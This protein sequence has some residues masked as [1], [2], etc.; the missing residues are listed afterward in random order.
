MYAKKSEIDECSE[1]VLVNIYHDLA[2]ES[3]VYRQTNATKGTYKYI[4]EINSAV[5]EAMTLLDEPVSVPLMYQQY[6][7]SQ[8]YDESV[9]KVMIHG[10][11][12]A[13]EV[14]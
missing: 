8:D 1:M 13:K 7:G 9:S 14:E 2:S 3:T 11:L 5:K 12:Y 10:V 6:S 4:L